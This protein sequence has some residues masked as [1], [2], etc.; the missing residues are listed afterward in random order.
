M[1]VLE[2]AAPPAA[3]AAAE[4]GASPPAPVREDEGPFPVRLAGTALTILAVVML[5][6]AAQFTVVGSLS[7]DR[8]QK[9]AYADFRAELARATAPVGSPPADSGT[10]VAILSIPAI[11]MREVV[12]EGTTGK[13][14]TGGPGHRR[15][16]VLPG[17]AGV[18]I[19]MGRR[20][21]YDGPFARVGELSRGD[22]VTVVTGQGEH[23][24][25]VLGVRRAGEPQPP[26][27][28]AGEGRLTLITG[29]GQAYVPVDVLRVDAKL[30]SPVQQTPPVAVATALLPASEQVM[31]IDLIALVPLVLW[32]ELLLA[33]ALA[34]SWLRRR[35]SPWH[36]WLI[37]LPV[38]TVT[39]LLVAGAATRLLPNLI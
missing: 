1:T 22:T 8:A 20:A 37:G 33:A 7:H 21:G 5:G 25:Q 26:A 31:G 4:V 19:L 9:V 15:D 11:G 10:A 16:T 34:V 12:F 3:P 35:L 38:L 14:L 28:A 17:Q 36:A 27:P 24:Y 6:F 23:T 29:D 39:G 13:V 30:T 2:S 32:G 18:S